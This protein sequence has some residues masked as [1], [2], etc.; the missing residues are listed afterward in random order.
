MKIS[1]I[2]P[3]NINR[4][5]LSEAVASAE[6]QEGMRLNEDYE[7]IVQHGDCGLSANINAALDKAKGEYIKTVAEDDAL[8]PG[9]LRALYTYAKI[10][11]YDFVCADAYAFEVASG[12]R[13]ITD[14]QCS[15][16][17]RTVGELARRNTIHGGTILYRREAMPHWNEKFW[18]AEEFDVTLRMAMA[19][20]KF[21]KLDAVVYWYRIHAEQKSLVYKSR[22]GE[23]IKARHRF[24]RDEIEYVYGNISTPINTQV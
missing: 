1:I 9:C 16:I 21:G 20:A 5:W 15:E 11:A 23:R 10:G 3:Y 22:D 6:Q 24:I 13:V 8:T 18:T 17:P 19:G 12:K 14:K 2:I 7:I 4:G